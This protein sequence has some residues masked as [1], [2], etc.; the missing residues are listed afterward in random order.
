MHY[1]KL[2]FRSEYY[3]G[4][5]KLVILYSGKFVVHIPN[6]LC[7][8]DTERQHNLTNSYYC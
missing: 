1:I 6:I 5:M 7:I 8:I 2:D 4:C 3:T